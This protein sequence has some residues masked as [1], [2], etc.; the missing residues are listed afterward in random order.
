MPLARGAINIVS[1]PRQTGKTPVNYLFLDEISSVDDWP[2]AIKW[3]ADNGLLADSKIILTG[4]SS[5]NLKKGRDIRFLPIDFFAYWQLTAPKPVLK[6]RLD[7]FVACKQLERQLIKQQ[8]NSH[9]FYQDFLLT[10]GFL[11]MINAF[12]KKESFADTI[13]LYQSA[14]KSE[15]AK[16]GKKEV[17]ARRVLAKVVGSLTAE[18]AYANVADYL[19]FFSDSFLLVETFFYNL[20]QKRIVIKKNKK[21]YPTDPFLFWIFQSFISGSNQIEEFYQKYQASPLDSQLAEAFVA[22]EL[23][24]TGRDFYFSRNSQELDFYIPS[25]KLGIEVKYKDRIFSADLAGLKSAK[26]KIVISKNVLEK[27]GD[28]LIIPIH[29]FGLMKI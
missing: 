8:I 4:S 29:L 22:S 19:S 9:Q 11:K 5:M 16:F 27:R 24:K 20:A 18:T 21:F 10:G 7:S 15:L 3:L 6:E 13:D 17:H 23:Y 2:Y 28:I 26:K 12:A 25:L 14:L 1:G